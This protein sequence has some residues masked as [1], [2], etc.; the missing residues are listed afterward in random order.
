MKLVE[1]DVA[2]Q[3]RRVFDNLEAILRGRGRHARRRRQSRRLPRRHGRLREDE[4]GLRGALRRPPAGALDRPGRGAPGRRAGGDRPR[5]PRR[6]GGPSGHSGRQ[7]VPHALEPAASLLSPC[8]PLPSAPAPTRRGDRRRPGRSERREEGRR[9]PRRSPPG[10][11]NMI[12]T[13]DPE[14]GELCALHRRRA[15]EAPRPTAARR[16][17][18]PGRHAAGRNPDDAARPGARQPLRRPEEPG[19]NA[20]RADASTARTRPRASSRRAPGTRSGPRDPGEVGRHGAPLA[21]A[22][23]RSSLRSPPAASRGEHRDRQY[24]IPREPASTT[25]RRSRPSAET[26]AR[27]SAQQRLIVFQ[28]A[29]RDLGRAPPEHRHDQGRAR[30]SRLST[31]AR[32]PASSARPARTTV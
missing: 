23:P 24:R 29:A 5:R 19:R 9:C 10:R 22:A 3:T 2:V 6:I 27:R 31:A 30:A 25:R 1:G 12:V 17:R 8:F 18:A 11:P 15:R 28:Q 26:R 13:R 16:P 21:A 7:G 14:T 32:R 4:R 20:S